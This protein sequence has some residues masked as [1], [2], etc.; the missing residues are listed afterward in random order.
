[1]TEAV[2]TRA[3]SV[4]I[5]LSEKALQLVAGNDTFLNRCMQWLQHTAIS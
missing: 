1:M 5:F 3:A 2:R 4:I